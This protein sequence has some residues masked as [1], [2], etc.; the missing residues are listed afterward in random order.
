MNWLQGGL[1]LHKIA[2]IL[3]EKKPKLWNLST[4]SRITSNYMYTGALVSNTSEVKEVGSGRTLA[5]SRENWIIVEDTHEPIISKEDFDK[6][7]EIKKTRLGTYRKGNKTTSPLEDVME[8]GHC[9][10]KMSYGSLKGIDR[11]FYCRMSIISDLG[12][13][14]DKISAKNLED[15]VFQ[16]V[17]NQLN[18]YS[19]AKKA[20]NNQK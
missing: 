9:G 6:V 10:G 16:A 8:C 3:N 2:K 4:L 11:F 7:Q 12:C 18:L 5:N 20:F 13:T 15:I 19:N 14:K 17:N 1:S